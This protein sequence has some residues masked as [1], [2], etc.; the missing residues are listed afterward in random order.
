[1]NV[2]DFTAWSVLQNSQ[3]VKRREQEDERASLH[4]SSNK[5]LQGGRQ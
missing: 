1:M 4:F 3:F 2:N 5:F